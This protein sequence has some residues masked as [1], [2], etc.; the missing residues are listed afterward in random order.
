MAFIV[1]LLFQVF[2]S[3]EMNPD[4]E[5][6]NIGIQ[7][8]ETA[9][10]NIESTGTLYYGIAT[11]SSISTKEPVTET[12]ILNNDNFA[13]LENFV[14]KIQNGESRETKVSKVEIRLGGVVIAS[15]ADFRKTNLISKPLTGFTDG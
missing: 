15:T 10:S 4:D 3:C 6:M 11:F 5:L 7:S 14:I 9:Y 13:S 1:C 2:P 12:V 8:L